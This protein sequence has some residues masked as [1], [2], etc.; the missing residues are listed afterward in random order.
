MASGSGDSPMD[1]VE[2]RRYDNVSKEWVEIEW[3]D[4]NSNS[5]T[6]RSGRRECEAGLCK[7]NVK[8]LFKWPQDTN[9]AASWTS[10]VRQ[11]RKNFTPDSQSR[12]CYRHFKEDDFTNYHSYQQG[13]IK[14]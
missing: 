9:G 12:L 5:E 10:F 3:T 11:K 1:V 6:K 14:L 13:L 4:P 2:T 7:E 8:H